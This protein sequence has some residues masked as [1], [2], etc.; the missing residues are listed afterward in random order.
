MFFFQEIHI[1][2]VVGDAL[3]IESDSTYL[4]NIDSIHSILSWI[5]ILTISFNS[6]VL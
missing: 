3:K 4:S 2:I 6:F 1:M 5:L